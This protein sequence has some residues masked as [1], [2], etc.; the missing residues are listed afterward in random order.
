MNGRT[1]TTSVTEVVEG[2][3]VALEAPTNLVPTPLNARVDLTW[4]DPVDKYAAPDGQTA[5]TP[6]DN[7][8]TWDHTIVVRKAGSAPTSPD[9]GELIYT[10]TTRNQH[11]Y[12]AY[13]D[14]SNVIN[15]TEY[16][17]AIYAV[18]TADVVSDPIV[19]SCKPIEGTPSFYREIG[20]LS[21]KYR[22]DPNPGSIGQY[23]V[24]VGGMYA[25]PNVDLTSVVDTFNESLTQSTASLYP[26]SIGGETTATTGP[27]HVLFA[28]GFR[29]DYYKNAEYL[30]SVIAYD[31]S[32]TQTSAPQLTSSASNIGAAT[33]L[34]TSIF[35]GGD[36]GTSQTNTVDTY[37]ESLTKSPLENL[38]RALSGISGGT[39]GTHAVFGGGNYNVYQNHVSTNKSYA[40]VIAYDKSMTRTTLTDLSVPRSVC[41]C[42]SLDNYIMFAG[43]EYNGNSYNEGYNNTADAYNSSLTKISAVPALS[44]PSANV[45]TAH[46]TS[47]IRN[48]SYILIIAGTSMSQ[49]GFT[50][51]N[52]DLTQSTVDGVDEMTGTYSGTRFARV[53]DYALIPGYGSSTPVAA[54][55]AI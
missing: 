28:G 46:P 34:N 40:T 21:Q 7:V 39:I 29:W 52:S 36:T 32:L 23:A 48:G 6:W 10:E 54:F 12:S 14:T 55:K 43:G 5:A 9:D 18:T 19:D 42:A 1:N 11:Q 37:D 8:A 3:Q 20:P 38:P 26:Y 33:L 24:F 30:N 51:Y 17:Y 31:T 45:Y 13:T 53:G 50:K 22:S 2:V 27:S 41:G 16:Y 44:I 4:T 49:S 35:V 47:A 25:N 15:N